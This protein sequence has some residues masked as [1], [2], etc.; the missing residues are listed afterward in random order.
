MLDHRVSGLDPA[1]G[2]SPP[3]GYCVGRQSRSYPHVASGVLLAALAVRV[4]PIVANMSRPKVIYEAVL[5][6]DD[7][8]GILHQAGAFPT[9]QEAQKVLDVWSAEGR[10]EPMAINIV[11]IYNTADEW[12]ADR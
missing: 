5:L 9:E 6:R 8:E 12:Q 10:R 1:G 2:N 3:L 4:S 11:C 7:E